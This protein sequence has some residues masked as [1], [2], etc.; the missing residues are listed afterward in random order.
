MHVCVDMSLKHR[1]SAG[2]QRTFCK[3]FPSCLRVSVRPLRTYDTQLELAEELSGLGV[4]PG[5]D[6]DCFHAPLGDGVGELVRRGHPTELSLVGLGGAWPSI[7]PGCSCD[8]DASRVCFFIDYDCLYRCWFWRFDCKG[9]D[10]CL[11]ARR[12]ERVDRFQTIRK[13]LTDAPAVCSRLSLRIWTVLHQNYVQ[14]PFPRQHTI[15][16]SSSKDSSLA[17]T[18]PIT[19]DTTGYDTST[20][21]N[22][23]HDDHWQAGSHALTSIVSFR[24]RFQKIH[25]F[26]FS[27]KSSCRTN[28]LHW[29]DASDK[30]S[31]RSRFRP[32]RCSTVYIL[33]DLL[34]FR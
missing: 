29:R 28:V 2:P 34:R 13:C 4:Q 25:F 33:M 6:R 23:E 11:D 22:A 27:D 15:L 26:E 14:L 10:G 32:S 18:V 7:A 19:T 20:A 12:S 9:L 21:R 8:R 17:I 3:A 5:T 24:G 1:R 16:V 31:S 30:K